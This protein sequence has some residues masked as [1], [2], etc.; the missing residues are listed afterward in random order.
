VI[1]AWEVLEATGRPLA[2]FHQ[3]RAPMI[4]PPRARIVIEPERDA[5]YAACERRFDAMLAAGAL[6]EARR[7]YARRLDPALPVMKALGAAELMAH[8]AGTLSLDEAAA[9]ARRNTRRFAKRQLT[10]F[11]NQA[12]AWPRAR[13]AG[14]AAAQLREA[15]AER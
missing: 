11:R 4:A 8:L 7:L 1:R 9:L 14:E 6:D 3:A 13:D 12:A 2:S 5:L 15:L 10:W